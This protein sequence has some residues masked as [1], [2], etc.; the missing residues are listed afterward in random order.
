LSVQCCEAA[1]ACEAAEACQRNTWCR[2]GCV[3][4]DCFQTCRIDNVA[5][6]ALADAA[7]TCAE[8]RCRDECGIGRNWS[9]V[10]ASWPE[11]SS[12][13]LEFAFG[14]YEFG[15][16]QVPSPGFHVRACEHSDLSCGDPIAEGVTSPGGIA[17][18]DF[19]AGDIGGFFKG[20]D[21]YV[22]VDVA[23]SGDFPT[24]YQLSPP[25]TSPTGIRV[26]AMIGAPQFEDLVSAIGVR[27]DPA[28]GHAIFQVVDCSGTNAPDVALSVEGGDDAVRPIYLD[29]SFTPVPGG[30]ATATAGIGG[31]LNVKPGLV[32]VEGRRRDTGELV[33]RVPAVIV[34]PGW[35]TSSDFCP[36]PL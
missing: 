15:T 14:L 17:V 1:A 21:H 8:D 13:T 26:T 18:F 31:L 16:P 20:F 30:K 29:G 7:V 32:S 19:A 34:R 35:I 9:C 28:R 10:P 25:V 12:K 36:S 22:E 33:G 4:L 11:D 6:A 23:R 27:L 2:D 5:G 3:T 24:L